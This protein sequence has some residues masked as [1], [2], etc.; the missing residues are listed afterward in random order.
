MFTHFQDLSDKS[1]IDVKPCNELSNVF[2]FFLLKLMTK[3][4]RLLPGNEL[5]TI[6]HDFSRACNTH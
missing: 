1:G 6:G 4:K 2:S 5:F 3:D